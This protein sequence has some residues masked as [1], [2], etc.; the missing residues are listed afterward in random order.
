[1]KSIQG[2]DI[3]ASYTSDS[4]SRTELDFH[5]DSPVV[6]KNATILCTTEMTVNITP[7]SDDFGMMPEVPVFHTAVAYDFPITSN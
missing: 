5:A 7:F 1:M 4:T 3:S 2:A 6:G